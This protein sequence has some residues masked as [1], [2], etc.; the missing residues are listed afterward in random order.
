MLLQNLGDQ[1][2]SIMVFSEMAHGRKKT[3]SGEVEFRTTASQ[4]AILTRNGQFIDLINGHIHILQFYR[5]LSKVKVTWNRFSS[6]TN[7]D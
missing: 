6:S 1:T 2:K 3:K 4:S 5:D 7:I